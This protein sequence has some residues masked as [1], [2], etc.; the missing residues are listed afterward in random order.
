[1]KTR[2]EM[3]G[4]NSQI[5]NNSTTMTSEQQRLLIYG[6][7]EGNQGTNLSEIEKLRLHGSLKVK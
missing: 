7:S 1:M 2:F 3:T 5:V 4:R 6:T